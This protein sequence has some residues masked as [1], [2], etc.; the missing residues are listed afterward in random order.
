VS[1]RAVDWAHD[2]EREKL[3][4]R[5]FRTRMGHEVDFVLM[6][7]G[8]P[9]VAI[10]VKTSDSDLAPSLLYFA[11]RARPAL[12]LQVV[13]EEPRERRLEDIG[14]TEVRVISVARLLANLP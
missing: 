4:L 10:E 1:R 8:K 12:A 11:E 14:K 13:L 3:Q 6:R 5:Y 2:V 7:A 9:W